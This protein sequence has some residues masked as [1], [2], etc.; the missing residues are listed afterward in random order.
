[1]WAVHKNRKDEG[2]DGTVSATNYHESY[3]GDWM[4]ERMLHVGYTVDLNTMLFGLKMHQRQHQ[5]FKRMKHAIN[6]ANFDNTAADTMEYE[7]DNLERQKPFLAPFEGDIAG[8][9][10]VIPRTTND[11]DQHFWNN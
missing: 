8:Q 9:T 10:H 5:P 3:N 1:M 2:R 6:E 7:Q 11:R 4:E